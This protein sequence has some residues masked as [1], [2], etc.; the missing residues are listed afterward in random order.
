MLQIRS[1]VDCHWR[2]LRIRFASIYSDAPHFE[3]LWE[4]MS[5]WRGPNLIWKNSKQ[6][7]PCLISTWLQICSPVEVESE[8]FSSTSAW[9]HHQINFWS[10]L[11]IQK[12]CAS[13]YVNRGVKRGG[14]AGRVQKIIN[15][16][17]FWQCIFR[18]NAGGGGRVASETR[19]HG[20]IAKGANDVAPTKTSE[21]RGRSTSVFQSEIGTRRLELASPF[22]RRSKREMKNSFFSDFF[23]SSIRLRTC[24]KALWVPNPACNRPQKRERVSEAFG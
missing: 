1:E 24:E 13:G 21:W 4:G 8:N 15:K 18:K 5:D 14:R 7:K 12:Q 11:E 16:I 9:L 17:M 6:R 19:W 10:I 22:L 2:W 3:A 23:G 20:C